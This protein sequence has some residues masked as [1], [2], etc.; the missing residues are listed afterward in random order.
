MEGIGASHAPHMASDLEA[1]LDFYRRWFDAVV[2]AELQ[3]S[4]LV[5]PRGWQCPS[6]CGEEGI[7]GDVFLFEETTLG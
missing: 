3:A 7:E 5:S 4:V 6:G 2:V 1:P